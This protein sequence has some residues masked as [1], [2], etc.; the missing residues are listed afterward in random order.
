[1]ATLNE[2]FLKDFANVL[3]VDFNWQTGDATA[4]KEIPVKVAQDMHSGARFVAYYIPKH[5]RWLAICMSLTEVRAE[6]I[7]R[8]D[9]LRTITGFVG[10]R[11]LGLVGSDHCVVANRVYVYAEDD[12]SDA[13]AAA[14]DA[15]CRTKGLWLTLRGSEYVKKKMELEK[16]LAFISHDSRDKAEVAGPIALGLEKLMCPVWYDE[17]SLKVGDHLRE[18]IERGL[19][20][21]KKCVLIL[22]PHF[23]SNN[24]WTKTEFNS[25][26]TREILEQ[27]TVVLPVWY[28]VNAKEV[29]EYSPSLADRVGLNW[30]RGADEV[31]RQLHQAITTN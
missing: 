15:F 14:L 26:F 24:G 25:I 30:D 6:A 22:S 12:P 1:V 5:P 4:A 27:R 21:A 8:S 28:K 2:Y 23:F 11:H 3:S 10:D 13:D 20:E 7:K 17:F 29:Y 19:K 31:I 18:S 9:G 16:P